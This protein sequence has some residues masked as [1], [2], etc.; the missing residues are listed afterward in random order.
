MKITIIRDNIC[1]DR[2]AIM[3]WFLNGLSRYV[4]NKVE[5]QYYLEIE[6]MMYMAINVK[7]TVEKKKIMQD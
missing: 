7:K 1:E 6:D 5:L 4:A 3:T 2:E